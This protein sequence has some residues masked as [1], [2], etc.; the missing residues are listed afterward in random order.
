LRNLG[1]L[2]QLLKAGA[3]MRDRAE[4]AE[5]N[6]EPIP[7]MLEN[8]A[9]SFASVLPA[10]MADDLFMDDLSRFLDAMNDDDTAA[11]WAKSFG[12]SFLP[13]GLKQVVA[14]GEEL[15]TGEAPDQQ[16]IGEKKLGLFGE[17]QKRL[18]ATLLGAAQGFQPDPIVEKMV[19]VGAMKQAPSVKLQDKGGN[20]PLGEDEGLILGKARGMYQK[21]LVGRVINRPGFNDLPIDRQKKLID[22]M[23]SRASTKISDRA[24]RLK[25]TGQPIT[26]RDL[27]RGL[28]V[29]AE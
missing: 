22:K 21:A 8:T 18:G 1:E 27:L 7:G 15:A 23:F 9:R 28:L 20:V 19:E 5:K 29:P 24:R 17:E 25:R 12:G 26:T 3:L 10:V 2:G 13:A 16:R 14:A 11:T 6:G 4:D